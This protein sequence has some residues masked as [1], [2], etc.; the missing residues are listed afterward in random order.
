M[1]LSVERL[2]G[3]QIVPA[4]DDV[5][6]LRIGVFA[7]YPYLY[8]GSLDYERDYLSA[9]AGAD[10]AVLVV[11]RDDAGGV[12]GAST[13]MPLALEHEAF[14]APWRERPPGIDRIFYFA[15]S[16]LDPAWRGH[17]IGHRFFDEREAHARSFGDYTHAC[18][19]GVVRP[20][21]HPA[22]PAGYRPLDDFWR[23]RGYHP[24]EGAVAHYAWRDRG[25]AH[26]TEKPLQFWMKPL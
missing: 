10:R 12:V 5:A 17:G 9:L 2:T 11:A 22:R 20:P 13:G 4:L 25:E 7:D 3:A 23:A 24:V 15:E 1:G 14:K 19:C 16:V 21:D 6:R 18:F 8:E 26:D